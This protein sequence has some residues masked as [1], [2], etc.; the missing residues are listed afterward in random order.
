[1]SRVRMLFV[2]VAGVC[3]LAATGCGFSCKVQG[4][5]QG[6]NSCADLQAAYDN[7][8]KK[9]DPPPDAAKLDDLDT[10]G[11]VNGCNIKQ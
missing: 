10:C 9:T 2:V 3:A 1:M 8:A 5:D 4:Q 11:T 6:F 7:E